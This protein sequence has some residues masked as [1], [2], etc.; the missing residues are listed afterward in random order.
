MDKRDFVL[1]LGIGIIFSV[2]VIWI[3][4]GVSDIGSSE[5]TKEEI[6]QK[7]LVWNMFLMSFFWK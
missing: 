1:G 4:Y 6:E 3:V 5:L 7:D 2:I